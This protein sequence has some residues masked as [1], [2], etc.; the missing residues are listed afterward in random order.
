MLSLYT[1]LKR[2]RTKKESKMQTKKH[3]YTLSSE[4][5]GICP[6]CG[7]MTLSLYIDVQTGQIV[8]PKVGLCKHV[9]GSRY[10]YPPRQFFIDK[11]SKTKKQVDMETEMEN[12]QEQN[13]QS[14][15]DVASLN[16][17]AD[18]NQQEQSTPT[19]E[20]VT[21]PI[22]DAGN[23]E[24]ERNQATSTVILPIDNP[25]N[26][27]QEPNVERTLSAFEIADALDDLEFMQ[28]RAG[29]ADKPKD[30]IVPMW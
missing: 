1:Y 30:R 16:V 29:C 5:K 8:D 19:S 20:P 4:Q 2:A 23:I 24:Q 14:S 26:E 15:E 3:K 10:H 9:S 12:P 27:E 17:N 22:V 25:D 21:S 13:K 28:R 7:R 6:L 18:N 11:H